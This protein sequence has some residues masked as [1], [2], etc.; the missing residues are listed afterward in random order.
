MKEADV[1]TRAQIAEVIAA[2]PVGIQRLTVEN[3]LDTQVDEITKNKIMTDL[4]SYLEFTDESND[5]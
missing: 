1:P 3:Y 4:I 2:A 5:E